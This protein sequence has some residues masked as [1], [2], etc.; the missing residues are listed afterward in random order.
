MLLLE[1]CVG[2]R[3][4]NTQHKAL[5]GALSQHKALSCLIV[6]YQIQ[7]FPIL[8]LC[9]I[10]SSEVLPHFFFMWVGNHSN[11]SLKSVILHTIIVELIHTKFSPKF[12]SISG[13][14]LTEKKVILYYTYTPTYLGS[15]DIIIDLKAYTAAAVDRSFNKQDTCSFI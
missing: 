8:V 4:L 2:T 15:D 1:Y 10:T 12:N 3:G 6:Y 9:C 11:T 13:N 5:S 14:K 7:L